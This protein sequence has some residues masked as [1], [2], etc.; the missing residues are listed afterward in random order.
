MEDKVT[1]IVQANAVDC[2]NNCSCLGPDGKPHCTVTETVSGSILFTQTRPPETCAH[3][4]AFG[5]FFICTCPVRK[6]L[7][8]K[9]AL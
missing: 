4:H 9:Y 7:F 8:R 1:K 5:S 3:Q 2:K 6:E